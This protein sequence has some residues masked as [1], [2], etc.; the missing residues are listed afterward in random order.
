MAEG[1]ALVDSESS[2]TILTEKALFDKE[3]YEPTITVIETA[4]G[5]GSMRAEGRGFATLDL[6]DTSGELLQVKVKALYC[7]TARHA[8]LGV[9]SITDL[10]WTVTLSQDE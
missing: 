6:R 3:L 4:E 9:S 10:N 2:T 8:L 5:S 7:P 1:W